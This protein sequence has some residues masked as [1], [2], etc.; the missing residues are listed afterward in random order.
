MTDGVLRLVDLVNLIGQSE[1]QQVNKHLPHR[2]GS[3]PGFSRTPYLG[4]PGSR[5]GLRDRDGT[6]RDRDRGGSANQHGK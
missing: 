4:S 6:G 2:P 5:P 3:R 1:N